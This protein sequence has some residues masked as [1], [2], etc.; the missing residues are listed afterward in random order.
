MRL[1]IVGLVSQAQHLA[2]KK[3]PHARACKFRPPRAGL[4]IEWA[5]VVRPILCQNKKR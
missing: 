3:R 4:F 2:N 5:D 1:D